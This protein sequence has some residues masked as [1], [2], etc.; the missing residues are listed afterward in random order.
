MASAYFSP[1]TDGES[2][3]VGGVEEY[4][5][6]IIVTIAVNKTAKGR[7]TC[8]RTCLNEVGL[9]TFKCYV[10]MPH[11]GLKVCTVGKNLR[12]CINKL[13]LLHGKVS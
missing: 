2:T 6:L 9:T 7:F 10:V 8:A 11:V 3:H 1:L 5:A 13:Y 4:G 12:K